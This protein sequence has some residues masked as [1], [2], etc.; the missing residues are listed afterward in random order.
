MCTQHHKTE[1]K[2]EGYGTF[3]EVRQHFVSL[4]IPICYLLHAFSII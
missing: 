4:F 1:F 3:P 2:P